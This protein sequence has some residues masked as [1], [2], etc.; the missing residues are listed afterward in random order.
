M[1]DERKEAGINILRVCERE[2]VDVISCIFTIN[3]QDHFS[4]NLNSSPLRLATIQLLQQ[5]RRGLPDPAKN[6]PLPRTNEN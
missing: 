3:T 1:F 2:E 5:R 6:A 4:S